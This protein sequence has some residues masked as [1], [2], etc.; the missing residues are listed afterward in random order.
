MRAL[1]EVARARTIAEDAN[2]A[3]TKFLASMSHELRT[4]L[5]AVLGFAQMI[6]LG[7]DRMPAAQTREYLAIILKSGQHLLDL[8]N[9]ILEFGKIENR[10]DQKTFVPLSPVDLARHC[11]DMVRE[12]AARREVEVVDRTG[13]GGAN[14]RFLGDAVWVRQILLNL[15]VNAVKYNRPGGKA[16][17]T[18]TRR[19]NGMVRLAVA[20]TGMGIAPELRDRVFQPFQRLGREAGQ[21]EGAGIGLALSRQLVMRMGGD[22]GFASELGKGSTFWF[23]LPAIKDEIGRVA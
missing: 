10:G 23:D 12:E 6:D 9:Q 2:A 22:I 13:E 11:L 7:L 4:P 14:V 15:L 17:L 20:D 21:I 8:V 1:G 16:I 18:A 19:V 5:N 3:K